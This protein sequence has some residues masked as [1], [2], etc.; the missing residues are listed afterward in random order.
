MS[1]VLDRRALA[2]KDAE[3]A[4]LACE[5]RLAIS[6]RDYAN[7]MLDK[8]RAEIAALGEQ[9]KQAILS[10]ASL[11]AE[12]AQLRAALPA[13][14]GQYDDAGRELWIDPAEAMRARC[15]AI[16]RDM[17]TFDGDAI[18]D[19]IAALGKGEGNQ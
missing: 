19:A 4:R 13:L 7:D 9:L 18:A 2:A 11:I 17:D 15:E 12:A 10:N 5:L 8:G 6:A 14:W 1:L 3:I 16:A